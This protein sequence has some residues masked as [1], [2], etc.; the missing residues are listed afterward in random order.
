MPDGFRHRVADDECLPE[1]FRQP[2]W[3]S[4]LSQVVRRQAAARPATG[5]RLVVAT[6]KLAA[7][8]YPLRRLVGSTTWAKRL[9]LQ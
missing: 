1:A 4:A 2:S 9:V 6:A 3:L 7:G 8:V 5:A